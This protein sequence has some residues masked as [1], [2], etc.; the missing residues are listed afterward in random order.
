MGST[1]NA[2]AVGVNAASSIANLHTANLVGGVIR[3]LHYSELFSVS[4]EFVDEMG[5]DFD[6]TAIHIIFLRRVFSRLSNRC[7][8]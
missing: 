4:V 5:G 7:A 2:K 1:V 3:K 6:R 8:R